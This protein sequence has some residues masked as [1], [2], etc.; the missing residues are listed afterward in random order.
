[1]LPKALKSFPKCNKSPNLVTRLVNAFTKRC[2]TVHASKIFL[3]LIYGQRL[4]LKL[5]QEISLGQFLVL[6]IVKFDE[7]R[8]VIVVE[9]LFILDKILQVTKVERDAE[10]CANPT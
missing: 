4:F 3:F 8:F 9:N 5:M 1:M 7:C 6:H 2:A 10:E